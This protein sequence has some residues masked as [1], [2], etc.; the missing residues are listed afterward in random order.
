MVLRGLS[1]VHADSF[2]HEI[3]VNHL[4]NVVRTFNNTGTL[5]ENYSPELPSQGNPAKPDFVGWT[6]LSP[7]A[8]LLEYVLG[9]R[10]DATHRKLLWDVRLLEAHGVTAYPIGSDMVVDL[11]CDARH[12]IND[13]PLIKADTNQPLTLIVRWACGEK[14][15]DIRP[16]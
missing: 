11:Q 3:A 13:E 5:W 6:G 7:I 4:L 16:L 8:I 1:H 14:T 12:S 10:A 9:L 15:L 2:A